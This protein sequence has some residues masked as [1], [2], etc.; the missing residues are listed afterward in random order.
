MRAIRTPL[1][2]ANPRGGHP[3][4]QLGDGFAFMMARPFFR[5]LLSWAAASNLVGNAVFFVV[6]L[7]MIQADEPPWQIGLVSLAAGAGGLLGAALAPSLIHRLPTGALT[8]LIGWA[9]CLPLIPLVWLS[10]P[11]QVALCTFA[12]LLLNPAGNAG[13]SAY[14]MAITPDHLQGRVGS[15]SQF[16]AMSVMPLSPVLGGFLL[17]HTSGRTAVAVLVVATAVLAAYLTSS[18][19]IRSVPRPESWPSVRAATRGSEENANRSK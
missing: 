19:T 7:R 18:R 8:V 1:P 17:T 6:T 9:C 13:I 3:L 2:A 12:L 5:V 4:R 15:A 11:W 10:A 16:T 14:R